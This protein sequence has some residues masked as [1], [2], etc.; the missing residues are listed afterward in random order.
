M[1][2]IFLLSSAILLIAAGI[3]AQN[4]DEQN[5]A[6]IYKEIGAPL[7]PLHIVC[8]DNKIITEKDLKDNKHLFLIMF[9]PTCG[10]CINMTDSITSNIKDFKHNKI[11]FMAAL[12]AADFLESF[13]TQTHILDYPQLQVGYDSASA[14]DKLFDYKTLPQIN[15]YDKD[16]KL[17]KTYNADIPLDSLKQYVD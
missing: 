7:P 5:A 8:K 9:N 15:I 6:S 4:K 11:V 3:N 17:V 1:K 13:Y 14:V 2:K 12:P 16:R 10:H